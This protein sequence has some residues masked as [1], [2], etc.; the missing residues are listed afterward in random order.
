ML[1]WV[2]RRLAAK[3]GYIAN[4]G[5]TDGSG[6]YYI[7]VDTDKCDGCGKCVEACPQGV[8]EV[9]TDD[10]DDLVVQV[11]KEHSKNLKYACAVCKP[12]SGAH[13]LKC[14][15]ACPGEAISHSW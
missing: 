7:I 5:Y 1:S 14:Q 8:L 4:Y 9:F 12:V 6:D 2:L 13:D 15:A 3:F 11:K 10:Y